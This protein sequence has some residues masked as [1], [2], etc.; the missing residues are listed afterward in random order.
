LA[1]ELK[2]VLQQ[3][4]TI[5]KCA[6]SLLPLYPPQGARLPQARCA[7]GGQGGQPPPVS[8]SKRGIRKVLLLVYV[9]PVGR[10]GCPTESRTANRRT[11]IQPTFFT[12]SPFTKGD[13][14]RC[15]HTMER[16]GSWCSAVELKFDPQQQ[17][18]NFQECSNDEYFLY[19]LS[20]SFLPS[21]MS[22]NI[23]TRTPRSRARRSM[24]GI[25]TELHTT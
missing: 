6:K 19:N 10:A 14:F 23:K 7:C 18:T 11:E 17:P 15:R 3:Q 20:T 8:P 4:S 2:F 1:V 21:Q 12:L 9:E 22:E 13:A 5:S 25:R 24:S 16:R